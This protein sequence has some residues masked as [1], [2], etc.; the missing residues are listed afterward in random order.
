MRR[1]AGTLVLASALLPSLAAR[2]GASL[3]VD[4]AGTTPDGR[5]QLE[6]WLRLTPTDA[7]DASAVPACALGGVEY[8]LGG[9]VGATAAAPAELSFG[10]KHTLRDVGDA[11]PG[12]AVSVG[13]AWSGHAGV[14]D[15]VIANLIASVPVP[16]LGLVHLNAGWSAARGRA[17][18]PTFGAG[19]E[20]PLGSHWLLLAEGYAQRGAGP[21]W[22][23]GLRRMLGRSVTADLLMGAD[24]HG[25]WLTLGLN[26]SPGEG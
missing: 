16:G 25:R 26:Y 18:A 22:Q 8:S 2:A 9:S 7:A 11:T 20:H 15:A 10:L 19:L 6:S 14:P 13:S 3:L 5:C 1:L 12:F 17:P 4:D 24:S 23:A 21:T